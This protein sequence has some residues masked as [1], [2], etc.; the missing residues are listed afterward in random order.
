MLE[1][2]YSHTH[3]PI[4]EPIFADIEFSETAEMP[5]IT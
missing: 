3:Q 5:L 2:G 4:V 1:M